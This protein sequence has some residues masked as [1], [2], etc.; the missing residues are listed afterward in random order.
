LETKIKVRNG[1]LSDEIQQTIRQ[2]ASKLTRFFDRT[3]QIQVVADLQH[4]DHPEIE[5]IVSAEESNHFV[6]SDSGSNVLT[7]L[8]SAIK[9]IEV[10][11]RKHKEKIKGHRGRD[12]RQTDITG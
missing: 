12:S 3:T 2:K 9:K 4:T 5:I 7:A 10:Q 6:A 1:S 8:D 11:L